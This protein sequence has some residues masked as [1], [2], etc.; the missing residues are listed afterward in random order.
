MDILTTL[1]GKRRS[2]IKDAD[3]VDYI[4][5]LTGPIVTPTSFTHQPSGTACNMD[6]P[7]AEWNDIASAD[8]T[9]TV[10]STVRI[11]DNN[12]N[13]FVKLILAGRPIDRT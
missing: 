2:Y 12:G 11:K 5:E 13:Y 10:D 8:Y 1:K 9:V 6:W 4:S 3:G 7:T